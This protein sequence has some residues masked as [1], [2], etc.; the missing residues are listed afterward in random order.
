MKWQ[1]EGAVEGYRSL[2][3]SSV[4]G[5]AWCVLM[6]HVDGLLNENRLKRGIVRSGMSTYPFLPFFFFTFRLNLGVDRLRE[7]MISKS[8]YVILN[9]IDLLRKQFLF[10]F[11]HCANNHSSFASKIKIF[12]SHNCFFF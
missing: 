11:F 5:R 6:R 8:R 9:E 2:F 10:L 1:A 4:K 12:L 7:R 3:Q